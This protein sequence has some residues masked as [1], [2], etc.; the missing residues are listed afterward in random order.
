MARKKAKPRASSHKTPEDS[1]NDDDQASS[2]SPEP[3][4]FWKPNEPTAG[5]LSQWYHAPFRD[6]SDPS[7]IYPTAEHYM[8]HH[9]AQLFHDAARAADV[10]S[11]PDPRKVKAY[12]RAVQNFDEAVWERERERV[13]REGNWCKFSLPVRP[14]SGEVTEG[15]GTEGKQTELRDRILATGDSVLAEASPF[16]RVWGIGFKA[17]N[18]RQNRKKWGP[19]LLGKCLME[20][21]EQLRREDEEKE[22]ASK[23]GEEEHVPAFLWG[24]V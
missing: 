13:V 17:E 19:N 20:V 14:K 10:L 15:G 3:V 8:M 5:F 23:G 16:D 9:K 24:A 12:G 18:A 11:E 7:K 21:R 1:S 4:Y 22:R 6:R 2:T